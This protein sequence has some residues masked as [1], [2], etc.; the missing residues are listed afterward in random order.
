MILGN[1][2]GVQSRATNLLDS[3]V[4]QMQMSKS[5]AALKSKQHFIS[6]VHPTGDQLGHFEAG[7]SQDQNA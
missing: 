7:I 2:R 6:S 3:D 4:Q 5:D 1:V